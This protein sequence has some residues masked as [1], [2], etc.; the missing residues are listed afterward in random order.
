MDNAILEFRPVERAAPEPARFPDLAPKSALRAD[1]GLAGLC[2]PRSAGPDLPPLTPRLSNTPLVRL[3]SLFAYVLVKGLT[4]KDTPWVNSQDFDAVCE[5]AGLQG[6]TP[7]RIRDLYN[8]GL[9]NFK[10]ISY[11]MCGWSSSDEQAVA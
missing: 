9:M 2:P 11:A 5:Y 7:D 8:S 1:S 4:E 10:R 6:A 3:Q